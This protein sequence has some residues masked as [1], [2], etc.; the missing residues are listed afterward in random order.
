MFSM[1]RE[2]YTDSGDYLPGLRQ[3]NSF[4]LPEELGCSATVKLALKK[5]PTITTMTKKP[6]SQ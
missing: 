1:P 6:Q 2:I 3:C 4:S 5:Q